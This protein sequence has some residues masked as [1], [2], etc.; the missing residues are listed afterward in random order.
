MHSPAIAETQSEPEAGVE[1]KPARGFLRTDQ[2]WVVEV[3]IWIPGF[4]GEFAYGDVSLEGEDG[5]DLLPVNPIEPEPEDPPGNIF[6]RLFSSSTYLK[7]F[8][9]GRAE[10]SHG[11]VRA[12]IDA[13][14]GVSPTIFILL[15]RASNSR[16]TVRISILASSRPRQP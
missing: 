5:Q 10:F 1:R 14:N 3:P 13:I 6:S 16:N 12:N 2:H 15:V 9:M 11:K 7:F 8:F 4:R